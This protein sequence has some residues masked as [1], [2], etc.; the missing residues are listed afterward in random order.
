MA[1][2]VVAR[3]G[4]HELPE[5]PHAGARHGILLE[6]PGASSLVEQRAKGDADLSGIP[7][8]RDEQSAACPAGREQRAIGKGR[9]A[10]GAADDGGWGAF[11]RVP[12]AQVLLTIVPSRSTVVTRVVYV[13]PSRA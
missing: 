3:L 12:H 11:V 2:H 5:A 8:L 1:H 4:E 9:T 10:V 13:M 7:M 6:H